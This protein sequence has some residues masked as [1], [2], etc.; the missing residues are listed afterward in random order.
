[1]YL[2]AGY[3]YIFLKDVVGHMLLVFEPTQASDRFKS[4]HLR[5]VLARLDEVFTFLH[6]HKRH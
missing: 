1:M 3:F 2:Y 6:T 4:F 5:I